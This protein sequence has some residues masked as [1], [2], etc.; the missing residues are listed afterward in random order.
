MIRAC[1]EVARSL[2]HKTVVIPSHGPAGTIDSLNEY[3]GM[4][5]TSRARIA[6]LIKSGES[7]EDVLAR[8]PLADLEKKWA[9][10]FV[11]AQVFVKTIY[12]SLI[13]QQARTR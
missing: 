9:W 12:R 10:S 1:K 11:P 7:E 4:M 13:A 6:T 5:E 2:D 8:R 3:I